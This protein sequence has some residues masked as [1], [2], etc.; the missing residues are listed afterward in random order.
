MEKNKLRKNWLQ[1]EQLQLTG[2]KK[3]DK[4]IKDQQV[5]TELH[6][7]MESSIYRELT[8]IWQYETNKLKTD[9]LTELW[10]FNDGNKLLAG[11]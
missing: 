10:T 1:S 5:M 2:E 11:K 3:Y 6:F 7:G 8:A 4:L 9:T